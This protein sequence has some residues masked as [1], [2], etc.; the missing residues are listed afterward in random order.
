MVFRKR[1]GP[2]DLR[3]Y[4]NWWAWVPG[5]N[6]RHPKGPGTS[7]EGLGQHP[8]VHVAYEDAEAYVSGRKRICRP[9][10]NGSSR[11]V[12]VWTVRHSRGGTT[13]FPTARRW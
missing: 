12:V 11:R 4:V 6:W 10:R 1:T 8:V 3:N 5:A 2:V 7:L 9:R 13:N